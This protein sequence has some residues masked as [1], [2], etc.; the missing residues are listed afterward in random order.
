MPTISASAIAVTSI[1]LFLPGTKAAVYSGRRSSRCSASSASSRKTPA[2]W[3]SWTVPPKP[4]CGI[5][6]PVIFQEIA[7]AGMRKATISTQYWATWV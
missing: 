7:A 4:N 6:L 1:M 3:P 5:G 2:C